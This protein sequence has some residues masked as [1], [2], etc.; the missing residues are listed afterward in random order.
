MSGH[1]SRPQVR[2]D[3]TLWNLFSEV[4]INSAREVSDLLVSIPAALGCWGGH[5]RALCVPWQQSWPSC[6]PGEGSW[7]ALKG[8]GSVPLA[9]SSGRAGL[10]QE[11]TEA[12][13]CSHRGSTVWEPLAWCPLEQEPCWAE[14]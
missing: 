11:H 7:S 13:L 12:F 14:V 3:N 10:L 6:W 9:G 4:L 8:L 1:V 5:R 2:L